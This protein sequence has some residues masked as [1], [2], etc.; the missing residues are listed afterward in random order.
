MTR[1]GPRTA[2]TTWPWSR[3]PAR[4][5]AARTR[6]PGWTG[7]KP[8]STTSAPRWR[9]SITDPASAEP[10]LRLATGLRWFFTM[11]GHAGEVLEALKV[12]LER[13]DARAPTRARARALTVSCHL[14]N[15]F[16]DDSA[17][18][19]LADEA[20]EDRPRPRR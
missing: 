10:G 3:P 11:R 7:W 8:S 4:T 15:H 20:L 1:R 5:C 9:Y 19:S 17:I 16:G 18:P 12:L 2:I 6:R 14:L 13:P